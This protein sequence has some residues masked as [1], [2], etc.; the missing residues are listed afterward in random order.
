[1][2]DS[3]ETSSGYFAFHYGGLKGYAVHLEAVVLDSLGYMSRYR[4]PDWRRVERLVFICMG[5]VC[6]SPYAAARAKQRGAKAVSYGLNVQ[7]SAPA[8]ADALQ[9]A[10]ERGIDLSAHRSTPL[11]GNVPGE[12][13]LLIGMEAAH[14]RELELRIPPGARQLTLLGLWSRPRRPHLYDPMGRSR[15]YFRTCYAVIYTA[16]D[17]ML[18]RIANARSMQQ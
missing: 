5:N 14:M 9:I 2:I 10:R 11:A 13:D 12:G 17:H 3:N 8:E 4:D 1:M 6:R 7:Y 18:S 16:I 15:D